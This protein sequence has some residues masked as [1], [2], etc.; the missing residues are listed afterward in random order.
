LN[1]V[2]WALC[3][4]LIAL[5]L[6]FC[7]WPLWRKSSAAPVEQNDNQTNAE[8]AKQR[9]RELKQQLAEGVIDDAQYQDYY[10]ELQQVLLDD[11]QEEQ[12]AAGAEPRNGRWLA[13]IIIWLLPIASLALYAG[14]GDPDAIDKQAMQ[15][16]EQQAYQLQLQQIAEWQQQFSAHPDDVDLALRLASAYQQTGNWPEAIKLYGGLRQRY[17]ENQAVLVGLVDSMIDLAH[18]VAMQNQGNL[19]KETAELVFKALQLAPNHQKGLYLAGWAYYQTQDF[20]HA[21]DY[22]QRLAQQL[23]PSDQAYEQIAQMIAEAQNHQAQA[24]T[25]GA[26]ITINVVLDAALVKQIAADTTVF[27]YAQAASG[28]KMPICIQRLT[29]AQLPAEVV[30]D[31]REAL[32]PNTR[33]ANFQ[34]LRLV[35]RVSKSGQAMP[36]SGDFTGNVEVVLPLAKQQP[37]NIVINQRVP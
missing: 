28:P 7:L 25:P 11:W 23:T 34:Q 14:L 31:D 2:F 6:A 4:A 33:M 1:T 32:N 30:L 3:A 36:Q 22:W 12:L 19:S 26:R 8:L 10:A 9:L 16:S 15:D 20:A 27:V 21:I 24:A 35:A 13:W 5:A 37:V 17:P 18:A 29:V